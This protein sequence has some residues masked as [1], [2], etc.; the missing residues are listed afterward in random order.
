MSNDWWNIT[1]VNLSDLTS[2]RNASV[3]D[4]V[5]FGLIMRTEWFLII[6][7]L[8]DRVVDFYLVK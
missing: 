5:E 6:I 4:E 2:G 1:L 8:K 3:I 7:V